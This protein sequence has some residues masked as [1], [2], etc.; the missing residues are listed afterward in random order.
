MCGSGTIAVL[1]TGA[2]R[3]EVM[4]DS[5]ILAR[6]Y[7]AA[8]NSPVTGNGGWIENQDRFFVATY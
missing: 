2:A 4:L 8:G 7:P 1:F 5:H 6:E 3:L